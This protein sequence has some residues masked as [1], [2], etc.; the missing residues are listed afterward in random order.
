MAAK[1]IHGIKKHDRKHYRRWSG[2]IQRCYNPKNRGFEQHGGV[3]IAIEHVW[4]HLNEKGL[5]NFSKWVEK[6]LAKQPAM[7]KVCFQVTRKDL[8][9]NYGPNNCK[10][11]IPAV[12]SQSRFNNVLTFE[13]VV[14]MRQYKKKN[15]SATLA[16]MELAFDQHQVNISRALR[17]VTWSNVNETEAPIKKRGEE[18]TLRVVES[19]VNTNPPFDPPYTNTITGREVDQ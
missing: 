10:L 14:A 12:V 19:F 4:S 2:I 5:V 9:K 1:K 7:V 18:A 3:G 13:I 16:T 15:P 8:K 11:V 6:E 17:G